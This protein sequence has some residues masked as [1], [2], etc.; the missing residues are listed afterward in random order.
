MAEKIKKEDESPPEFAIQQIYIKDLSYEAPGTPAI[1]REEWQPEIKLDMHIANEKLD[2]DTY[3]IVL[4]LTVTANKCETILFIAEIKQAGIFGLK[5]FTTS[6]LEEMLGAFCP[7]ILFPYAREAISSMIVK[8]GFPPVFL[9]PMNFDALYAQH[10][11]QQLLAAE[12]PSKAK[13]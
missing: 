8:G 7:T 3:E 6:K 5:G 13:H 1:F 11:E 9:V 4:R 12:S 2:E 10:K